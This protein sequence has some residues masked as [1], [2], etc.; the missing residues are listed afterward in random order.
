MMPEKYIK[1]LESSSR[2]NK[3]LRHFGIAAVFLA[4]FL[5]IGPLLHEISHI[6][7]LEFKGCMYYFRPG[8]SILNGFRAEVEPLCSLGTAYLILFYSI[9]YLGT[10]VAGAALNVLAMERKDRKFSDLLAAA[11]TGMLLSVL[12]TIG[13]EGDLQNLLE[14]FNMEGYW[15]LVSLFVMLGVFLSSLKGVEILLR[16]EREE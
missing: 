10:L 3:F 11:G 14:I 13:V 16:L 12:S 6:F 4:S 2:R 7:T 9:G 8:F 15:Q 1:D 5:L